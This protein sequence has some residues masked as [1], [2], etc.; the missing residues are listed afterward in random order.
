[1][2]DPSLSEPR[3]VAVFTLFL[4]A[5]SLGYGLLSLVMTLLVDFDVPAIAMNVLVLMAAA[6]MVGDRYYKRSGRFP[7]KALSWRLATW[8]TLVNTLLAFV[9]LALFVALQRWLDEAG[10][11]G[12][13]FSLVADR[14]M[15]AVMQDRWWLLPALIA[16]LTLLCLLVAR[17]ALHL[18]ARSAKK[19]AENQAAKAAR[20]RP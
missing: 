13:D 8:F 10:E 17:L 15:M 20:P 19:H 4:I 1:M 14:D 16:V 5:F 18:G 9:L 11:R 6:M 2:R 7:A 3:L 12:V